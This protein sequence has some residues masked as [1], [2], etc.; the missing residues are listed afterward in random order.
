M[1]GKLSRREMLRLSTM[2]GAGTLVAACAGQ[3]TTAP[4]PTAVP[5]TKA[6]EATMA[7][8]ATKAPE[9][10]AAPAASGGPVARNRQFIVNHGGTG[11]K[12]TWVDVINPY[13]PGWTHQE[14]GALLWDPLFYYSVFADKEIPWLA[15]SGTYNADYTQLTI[16]L[17]KGVEWSDGQPI[18]S[19]DFKWTLDALKAN[20]KLNYHAQVADFVKEVQTPDDGTLVINFNGAQPRFKFELLSYKFDTG[21]EGFLPKHWFEAKG[22]DPMKIQDEKGGQAMVHSGMW[23]IKQTPEQMIFDIRQDWWG[24]K[25]GF[26]KMPDVK[27][28]VWIPLSDMSTAPARGEQ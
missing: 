21:I 10:T 1:K 12:F 25:T 5:A 18:T 15:E 11:G 7:P 19:A 13:A 4:Q 24:F 23:N 6:P 28:V 2:V 27:Q 26:Q 17:R 22:I 3:A 8:E 20:D 9:A 14:G 16:K